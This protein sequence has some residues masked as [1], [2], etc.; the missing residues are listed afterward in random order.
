MFVYRIL[1]ADF[2]WHLVL[3]NDSKQ[4]NYILNLQQYAATELWKLSNKFVR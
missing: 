2:I 3:V 4:W 1:K